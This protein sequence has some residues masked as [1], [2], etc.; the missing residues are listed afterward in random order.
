MRSLIVKAALTA[1]LITVPLATAFAASHPSRHS[2]G[3]RAGENDHRT[4]WARSEPGDDDPLVDPMP[5][6]ITD[7][8]MDT[9]LAEISAADGRIAA[10][11]GR[12]MLSAAEVRD[13]RSQEAA[14]RRQAIQVALSDGMI[15]RFHYHV[16]EHQI[17]DLD[18]AISRK[19]RHA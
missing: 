8:R 15:S 19:V 3:A 9:I 7:S 2:H 10:D 12:M 17:A 5:M 18:R 11:S 16:I 1:I 13:L 4:H 14:I 6:F